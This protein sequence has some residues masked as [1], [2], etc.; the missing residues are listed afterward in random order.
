MPPRGS[1][2]PVSLPGRKLDQHDHEETILSPVEEDC[3]DSRDEVERQGSP[4]GP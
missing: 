1:A 3:E 4:S 2:R